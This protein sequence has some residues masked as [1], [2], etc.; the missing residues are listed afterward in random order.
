VLIPSNPP[1]VQVISG[2]ARYMS[3]KCSEALPL[4]RAAVLR[5]PTAR[6]GH[7]ALAATYVRLGRIKEARAE[8]AEVLRIEPGYTLDRVERHLR[9]FS[10]PVH[11]ENYFDDLRKAGL[12]ER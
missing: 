1:L 11:A 10:S 9:R 6:F 12:P 2:F 3:N 8:A 7:V 5:A 4:L